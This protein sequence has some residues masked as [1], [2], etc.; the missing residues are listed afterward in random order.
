MA[1]QSGLIVCPD[2]VEVL[3]LLLKT[4]N[5]IGLSSPVLVIDSAKPL[6]TNVRQ[7]I[8]QLN[9]TSGMLREVYVLK[10]ME[11]A[12]VLAEYKAGR[13]SEGQNPRG[14]LQR[15]SNFS[16]IFLDLVSVQQIPHL[17][18]TNEGYNHDQGCLLADCSCH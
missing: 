14:F 4:S 3:A 8:Y 5:K 9:I 17:I 18:I 16:G 12:N 1:E 13:F 10:S 11:V 6:K 2:Q 7:Q 15:R